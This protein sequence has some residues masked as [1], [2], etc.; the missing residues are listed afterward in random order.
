MFNIPEE[1]SL[2]DAM[3]RLSN[4]GIY[5]VK[6]DLDS[7]VSIVFEKFC[8][9]I[10]RGFYKELSHAGDPPWDCSGFLNRQEISPE[11]YLIEV[12]EEFPTLEQWA[13]QTYTGISIATC[14]SGCGL[15]YETYSS[16]ISEEIESSIFEL[17]KEKLGFTSDSEEN[18]EELDALF[19]SNSIYDLVSSVTTYCLSFEPKYCWDLY[20]KV[21]KD[22]IAE[23]ERVAKIKAD[24]IKEEQ[25]QTDALI[26]N[27]F[28]DFNYR[29]ES[30]N[31]MLFMDRF[32]KI[33]TILTLGELDALLNSSLKLD[34][35]NRVG[36]LCSAAVKAEKEKRMHVS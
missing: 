21:M 12:C 30:R 1:K 10:L 32:K 6:K 34:L 22:K 35:S 26:D 4:D 29:I 25:L 14:E 24:K 18:E 33:I 28:G 15:N 11:K 36:F 7:I 20:S 2:N 9:E 19:S 3:D 16:E 27:Y 5:V 31:K 17:V 8:R 23:E 13:E